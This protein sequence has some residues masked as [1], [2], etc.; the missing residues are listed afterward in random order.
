VEVPKW[1]REAGDSISGREKPSLLPFSEI[2]ND[3]QCCISTGT[4]V[5]D[6][7]LLFCMVQTYNRRSLK[8]KA[9]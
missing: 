3:L 9:Y 6:F 7:Y 8:S 4:K 1:N 5:H 2:Q